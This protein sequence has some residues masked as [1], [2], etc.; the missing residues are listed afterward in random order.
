M[1]EVIAKRGVAPVTKPALFLL[2]RIGSERYALRAT[3]VAEVL[4]RVALKPIA[5][6]PQWVAGVFAYRGAVVPVIDLSALTF[7]QPAEARTSTRLVLVNYRPD[8]AESAQWLG[9][10][11]EQATDTLRCHPEDFQPYGL[12][13]R[14]APYLGPVREDAHG[15][16]QWVRV[17]DLLDES[18]RA[19]LFPDPPR[20]PAQLEAQA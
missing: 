16:V 5:R 11:L 17:E 12:D 3:E 7:G 18:V 14:E 10:I 20:D 19:L 4:P 1:N 9:L 2:F 6:A 13:N 15:L 8:D